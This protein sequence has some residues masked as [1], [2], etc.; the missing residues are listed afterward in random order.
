[1][2]A[3]LEIQRWCMEDMQG[4]YDRDIELTGQGKPRWSIAEKPRIKT[5]DLA[6]IP[7]IKATF[8]RYKLE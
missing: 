8:D 7:D 3:T 2:L 6:G 1:M 4:I 5:T